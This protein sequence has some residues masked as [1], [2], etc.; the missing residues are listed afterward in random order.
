VDELRI[1]DDHVRILKGICHA[2]ASASSVDELNH[3]LARWIRTALRARTFSYS[4]YVPDAGSLRLHRLVSEGRAIDRPEL[5]DRRRY[6]LNEKVPVRWAAENS[7]ETVVLVPMAT[8]GEAFGV[9]ELTGPTAAIEGSLET[10]EAIAAQGAIVLRNLRDISLLNNEVDAAMRLNRIREDR[11]NGAIAL[12]AHEIKSPLLGTL[13][14]MQVLEQIGVEDGRR[15]LQQAQKQLEELA[16]LT[17][18]LLHLTLGAGESDVGAIELAE[19][20]DEILVT[21]PDEDRARVSVL[22]SADVTA[23][24]DSLPLR[25][26]IGHVLRHALRHTSKSEVVEVHVG[27]SSS[28]ALVTVID[29]G[30]PIPTTERENLFDPFA[31]DTSGTRSMDSLRL[32]AARRLIEAQGGEISVESLPTGACF[33]ILIPAA[34]R[35]EQF[36]RS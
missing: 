16:A 13:A 4:L 21:L 10:L 25:N 35:E 31:R 26:A 2:F 20:V 14:V 17:D 5:E 28:S 11:L 6:A 23:S 22:K 29:A 9:L 12:T 36:A 30:P 27:I 33:R 7:W 15:L 24:G 1:A 8:C 19:V 32:F 34:A 18:E 3:A